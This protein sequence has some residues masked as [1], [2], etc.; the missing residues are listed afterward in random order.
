MSQLADT[1]M[2]NVWVFDAGW[3]FVACRGLPGT[4]YTRKRFNTR[5][6]S[7]F[8]NMA[9]PIYPRHGAGCCS[10]VSQGT[11]QGFF[12][13]TEADDVF[14]Y[15]PIDGVL[16]L[17]W[18]A[19]FVGEVTA[20]IQNI[21]STL[22]SPFFTIRRNDSY[23]SSG[24]FYVYDTFTCTSVPNKIVI[25]DT[26]ITWIGAPRNIIN[27][28]VNQTGAK[29]DTLNHFYTFDCTTMSTQ[30]DLVFTFNDIKYNV[31]AEE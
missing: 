16:G 21:V 8:T 9:K 17:A 5:K 14:S 24:F 26:G 15:L 2:A 27:G 28:V 7:T 23:L 1:G 18:P 4:N 11:Q 30:P 29:Y 20:P 10:D 12:L 6:S 25:S 31:F 13:V 3:R 19:L 22:E